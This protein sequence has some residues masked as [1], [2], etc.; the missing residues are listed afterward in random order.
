MKS[1]GIIYLV[2]VHKKEQTIVSSFSDRLKALICFQKLV[3]DSMYRHGTT[4]DARGASKEFCTQMGIYYASDTDY[5]QMYE[6]TLDSE[7]KTGI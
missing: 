2:I 6:S 7:D 3:L 5:I 4:C 1:K